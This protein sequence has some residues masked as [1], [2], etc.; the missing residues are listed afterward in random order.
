MGFHKKKSLNTV[1]GLSPARLTS[2]TLTHV[3]A[4][5]DAW[6]KEKKSMTLLTS[7]TKE[8]KTFQRN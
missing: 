6:K 3:I 2:K 7:L 5:S 8:E 1:E 4:A